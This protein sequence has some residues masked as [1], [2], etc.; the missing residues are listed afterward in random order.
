MVIPE[1]Q[2]RGL[3]R[4][5]YEGTTLA[6]ASRPAAAGKPLCAEVGGGGVGRLQSRAEHDRRRAVRH[7]A[8]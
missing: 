5:E 1:L 7:V 8:G 6:R 4:T 3:F 2:R